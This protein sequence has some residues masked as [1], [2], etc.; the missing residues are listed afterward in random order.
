M[1]VKEHIN[2]LPVFKKVL[3]FSFVI[4]F[5]LVATTVVIGH[6]IL[7]KQMEQQ[8]R[9]RAEE[10]TSLWGSTINHRDL[11]TV[12]EV[13][14]T[15]HPLYRRL[16]NKLTVVNEKA[17][18][19]HALLLAP[20]MTDEGILV[21]VSSESYHKLGVPSFSYYYPGHIYYQA[22]NEALTKKK[23]VSTKIYHDKYGMW[24]AA[25]APIIGYNGE[26]AGVLSLDIDAEIINTYKKNFTLFLLGFFAI[27]MIIGF[28]I[29]K[30]GFKKVLSPLNEII[31]GLNEVS[32]GNFNVKLTSSNQSDLGILAERFNYMTEQL[33]MLFERLSA[34]TEQIGRIKR[35]IQ[36]M[37]RLESAIDEMD[38]ILQRTKIQRELQ[39]AEKMNAI[40]QL[41]ASVAHEIR[42]PMTVVK[43]FLQI[44][45]AKEQMSE[46]ERMY[47]K[48]MIDELNRAET[49]IND[50]LSLARPDMERIERVDAGLLAS[51]V[52]DLMNSYALMS[53]NIVFEY[54]F[55]EDVFIKGNTSELKQVLINILKNGIEAMKD[56]G[57]LSLYVYKTEEY[58]VFEINDTGIGMSSDE[59][60]RLGTA[61][62]SLK[63]KGTG[64]GLMVCYQIIDRMK[65]IIEVQ[66]EKGKGTTFKIF[67][68]LADL[69]S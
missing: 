65:G 16:K 13:G 52:F 30:R 26:V 59:L 43:G 27:T 23:V 67:V 21:L 44:F 47:I 3:L 60:D 24:I 4:S 15:D 10:M 28:F 8:L 19:N 63:E 42:N 46:E 35:T 22:Y 9:Y 38:Q 41:A 64:I 50:Y 1:R 7:T 62:Y 69:E 36:P 37:H 17:Y 66:S 20:K 54:D 18:Y 31:T 49:I 61:F 57:T 45:L 68:P 55:P 32:A 51:N 29:L 48:L 53:K 11:R 12:I 34:T 6:V 2:N 33:T 58:G 56:G 25:F 40:G 39:R 14:S 5:F